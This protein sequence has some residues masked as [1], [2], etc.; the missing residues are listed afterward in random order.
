MSGLHCVCNVSHQLMGNQISEK[1][2]VSMNRLVICQFCAPCRKGIT[3]HMRAP[4]ITSSIDTL[5]GG[6]KH[7]RQR[8]M[9]P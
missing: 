7:F 2:H 4:S 8:N 9:L 3:E 5:F 1:S 6:K